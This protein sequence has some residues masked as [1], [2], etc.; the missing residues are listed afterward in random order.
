MLPEAKAQVLTGQEGQ[1]PQDKDRA[2]GAWEDSEGHRQTGL[3]PL[4]SGPSPPGCR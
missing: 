1:K 2:E 4:Y 3:G